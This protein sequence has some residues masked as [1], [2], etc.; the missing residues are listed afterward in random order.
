MPRNYGD[1]SIFREK[2]N[3]RQD[4]AVGNDCS[5]T[6]EVKLSE[7]SMR[8]RYM[9][10]AQRYK[11]KMNEEIQ[12]SG[13]SP[14]QSELDDVLLE[15][16]TEREEMAEEERFQQGKKSEKDHEKVKDNR[17]KA[18]EKLSKRKKRKSEENCDNPP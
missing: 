4:K 1:K 14:E 8:E 12:A 11:T 18:M 2:K 15:E 16:L 13:I 9:R 5:K 6:C 10:I 3:I 7:R 17:L